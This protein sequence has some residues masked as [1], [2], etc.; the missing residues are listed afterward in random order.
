MTQFEVGKEYYMT[1]PCDHNCVWAYKVLS[2]TAQTVTLQ[3]ISQHDEKPIRR[4]ISIWDDC[5][6]V[7]PLGSYSM[8][9]CLRAVREVQEEPQQDAEPS[10]T[11]AKV[12]D[13]TARLRARQEQQEA[14]HLIEKFKNEY[15]PYMTPD[16]VKKVFTS[17]P[18]QQAGMVTLICMRIDSERRI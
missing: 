1:S 10:V 5:E 3:Q 2:R 6:S 4:K 9:P 15:L 12:I 7:M 8:A 14:E 17:P 13:F 11:D 18:D 16:D